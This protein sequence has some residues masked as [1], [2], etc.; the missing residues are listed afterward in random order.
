M[1]NLGIAD[2][3]SVYVKIEAAV[4]TLKVDVFLH[5]IPFSRAGK[6]ARIYADRVV[7]RNVGRVARIRIL[8]VYVLYL[9]IAVKLPH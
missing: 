8:H 3:A 1:R 4:N 7:L 2:K 9:V 6:I 5:S